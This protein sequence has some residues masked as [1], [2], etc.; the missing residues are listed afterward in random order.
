MKFEALNIPISRRQLMKKIGN[1]LLAGGATYAFGITSVV[2]QPIS[3]PAIFYSPHQ[4]DEAI[5]MA[6][7][8]A[9]HKAAGRKVFLVLLTNG[10]N[11]G[12]LTLVN[13]KL[14]NI[15]RLPITLE[16]M[17]WGRRSEFV[18][19]GLALGVDKVFI[20][21]FA[22]GLDDRNAYDANTYPAFVQKVASIIESFEKQYPGAS[23]KLAANDGC[24]SCA[25]PFPANPT[26]LACWEA[27]NIVRNKGVSSDFRFYRIYEFNKPYSQRGG[28][29]VVNL[30]DAW[31][32]LK[33]KAL[34]QYKLWDP[35][36]GRYGLGYLSVASLIDAAYSDPR[37][38]F[39]L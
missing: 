34:D 38:F 20:V 23:H 10:V 2:G 32:T 4:D 31:M 5:G 19:S 18:A 13:L 7:A 25:E 27:A 15:G 22:Q 28:Q 9:E 30:P 12:L 14:G 33:R 17:M 8:I 6:G 24:T 11:D 21:N 35:D 37:E 3:S 39:D 36:A 1:G 29:Y 26:H 16:Q